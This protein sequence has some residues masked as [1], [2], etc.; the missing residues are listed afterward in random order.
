MSRARLAAQAL[1]LLGAVDGPLVVAGTR[2]GLG[3]GV[4]LARDGEAA[5]GA[6]CWFLGEPADA[7]ARGTRLVATTARLAPGAP[8][9]VVDHNQ[10]R[11]WWRRIVGWGALALRGLVPSRARY[12]VAREVRDHGFAIERLRFADGERVQLVLARRR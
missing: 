10:P 8:F 3:P 5:A 11:A 7:A 4:R 9:V 12:P 1:E 6:I 2:G